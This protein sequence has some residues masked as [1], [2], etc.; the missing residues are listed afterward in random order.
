LCELHKCFEDIM[1]ISTA[2][3]LTVDEWSSHKGAHTD[4][5]I[6]TAV[7]VSGSLIATPKL[8]SDL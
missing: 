5:D 8:Q 4:A 7:R 2:D 1:L 6:L 3:I